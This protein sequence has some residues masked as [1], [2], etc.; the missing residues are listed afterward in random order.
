[1]SNV[2]K[3]DTKL[4]TF[5]YDSHSKLFRA[6][7]FCGTLI[8]NR[9]DAQI[10]VLDENE[11]KPKQDLKQAL[12]DLIVW[13]GFFGIFLQDY[14]IWIENHIYLEYMYNELESILSSVK[15][16]VIFSY[17]KKRSSVEI[18]ISF[19]LRKYW[20]QCV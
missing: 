14:S 16:L 19:Q 6:E 18:Y 10:W 8:D 12:K 4:H 15:H 1:M 11:R 2:D 17:V 7:F 9:Q 13:S 20:E 3:N 5:V